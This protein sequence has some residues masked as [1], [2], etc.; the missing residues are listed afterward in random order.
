MAAMTVQE[1]RDYVR[2]SL[3]S[4]ETELPDALLDV[5]RN[6]AT[7]RVQ[8]T[9]EPWSFYE[10]S[11]TFS[12]A[13]NEVPFSSID[14]TVESVTSIEGDN[15]LLKYV[16]HEAA[17]SRYAWGT[18]TTSSPTEWSQHGSSVFIW[19]TPDSTLTLTARGRRAPVD[20]TASSETVDLPDEFHPLIAEYMLARAYEQQDDDIM[21]QQKF[22][23]FEAE[24]EAYRR[25]YLRASNA[26][27]QIMGG[28]CSYNSMGLPARQAYDWE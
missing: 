8:R 22:G 3:D 2:S 25:R 9:F 26:G 17:V 18:T 15:W 21:S 16:A 24:L 14:T 28:T 10:T 1:M 20:A 6:S 4:D 23:R 27:V 12:T 7:N 19:P 5:W 11:W 13:T